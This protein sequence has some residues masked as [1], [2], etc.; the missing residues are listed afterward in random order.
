MQLWWGFVSLEHFPACWQMVKKKR[1]RYFKRLGEERET[2]Q[3][4][5]T[6]GIKEC[7]LAGRVEE[8]QPSTVESLSAS[9]ALQ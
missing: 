9:P 1:P 4:S 3:S 5:G 8:V 2:A 7:V 6:Q